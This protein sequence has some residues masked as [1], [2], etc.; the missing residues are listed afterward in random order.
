MIRG[1]AA[2][3]RAGVLRHPDL[4]AGAAAV[5]LALLLA[6]LTLRIWHA[7]LGVP[8]TY[9]GDALYFLALAKQA[10]GQVW[11]LSNPDLG[12]PFGQHLQDFPVSAAD[13]IHVLILKLLGLFT[14]DYVVAYNLFFLLGFA[15]IAVSAFAV[16]RSL[17]ASQLAAV[18]MAV[19]FANLPYHFAIGEVW[20]FHTAYWVIPIGCYLV[21]RV[22]AEDQLFERSAAPRRGLLNWVSRRSL[23]T[24]LLCFLVASAGVIYYSA[25]TAMLVLIA[26]ALVALRRGRIRAAASGVVIAGA[27]L[28]TVAI[29]LLPTAV[30]HSEHGAAP[31]LGARTAPDS[32]SNSINLTQLV[33][34]ISGDRIPRL[35]RLRD[36]YERGSPIPSVDT[37]PA[38][39]AVAAF[40]L[41]WSILLVLASGVGAL[42]RTRNWGRQ[43]EAATAAVASLLIAT[44]GG[45]SMLFA[46]LISPQLRYWSRLS[47]FIA[48]FALVGVALLLD[49]GLRRITVTGRR[50]LVAVGACAAVLAVGGF[51]QTSDRYIPPYSAT[52]ASF[53]SDEEI[54]GELEGQ[55]PGGA[56]VFQLPYL[57]YPE[58]GPTGLA[59]GYDGLRGYLHSSDLRWSYGATFRRKEDWPAALVDKPLGLV[60]PSIAAA[61]FEGLM[62]DRFAY[63]DRAGRLETALTAGLG[64][65]PTVSPDQRFSVFDL[66]PYASELTATHPLEE[67]EGLASATLRPLRPVPGEGL[68]QVVVG[69]AY[70]A[71]YLVDAPESQLLVE[72]PSE[73]ERRAMVELSAAPP[74]AA[75]EVALPDGRRLT[76]IADRPLRVSI[77]FEPGSTPLDLTIISPLPGLSVTIQIRDAELDPFVAASR[78]DGLSVQ[79]GQDAQVTAAAPRTLLPAPQ[80]D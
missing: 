32:E 9:T 75:V 51:T 11:Y 17:G 38:L 16:L 18:V 19:L 21:L 3:L 25:F 31:G 6:G 8:F 22:L 23:L 15:M 50:W 64:V 45:F 33:L 40:G 79:T 13:P 69:S 74:G 57:P 2:R 26:A 46:E 61:G 63:A 14:G 52:A 55:L 28:A 76:S 53:E 59:Y 66:R 77:V 20:P 68:T 67:I 72:N 47:P 65:A 36:D 30:Y 48:F 34:P 80:P 73:T 27:I 10:L 56:Q 58:W 71:T 43:A 29:Y 70:A 39:G 44:T 12:A 60:L 4:V 62:V 35:R 42:P 24:L 5:V 1:L 54:V 78:R 49:G 41:L 7:D 37:A